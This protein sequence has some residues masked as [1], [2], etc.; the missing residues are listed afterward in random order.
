MAQA[1]RRLAAILS[2][3]VA[4]YSRLM[5]DDDPGTMAALDECHRVFRQHFDTYN[6]RVVDT[7]GDS[8]FGVFDSIADAVLC[9]MVAQ[10][11]LAE[12]NEPRPVERRMLFRIGVNLGDI[13]LHADGRVYGDGVNVEARLQAL[14]EPVDRP[15][16]SR[17]KRASRGT[18]RKGR[19]RLDPSGPFRE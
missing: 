19:L 7:A 18:L 10:K 11:S 8:V 3:D 12:W 4:G 17:G 9:A 5:G 14:A 2:A 16:H 15:P 6:G 13:F 1:N